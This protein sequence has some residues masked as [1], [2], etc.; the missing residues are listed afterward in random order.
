V[1]NAVRR[2]TRHW[3]DNSRKYLYNY[4]NIYIFTKTFKKPLEFTLFV[5]STIVGFYY[6]LLSRTRYLTT[7]NNNRE[8]FTWKSLFYVYHSV[9]FKNHFPCNARVAAST[10]YLFT[11]IKTISNK[12]AVLEAFL[13]KNRQELFTRSH[14]QHNIRFSCQLLCFRNDNANIRS[15]PF[16]ILNCLLNRGTNFEQHTSLYTAT[17]FVANR[18]PRQIT[19]EVLCIEG[20]WF[21]R[22]E[23]MRKT[24]FSIK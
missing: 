22:V 9:L 19:N 18:H 10:L 16:W 1:E 17:K 12:Y 6:L 11:L 3:I 21:S 4:Y 8:K 20:K 5:L 24:F 15:R 13:S 2:N 23:K 7:R 14:L